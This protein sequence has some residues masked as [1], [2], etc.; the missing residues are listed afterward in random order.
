MR[1][2]L[3]TTLTNCLTEDDGDDDDIV[4]LVLAWCG[5]EEQGKKS[6]DSWVPNKERG[7]N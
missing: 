5:N 1:H 3:V 6:R 4:V 2:S 7:M